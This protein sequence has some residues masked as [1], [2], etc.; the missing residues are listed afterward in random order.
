MRYRGKY[1]PPQYAHLRLFWVDMPAQNSRSTLSGMGFLPE[2]VKM[3]TF[4]PKM[5]YISDQLEPWFQSLVLLT[6][7]A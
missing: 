7:F 1:N 2:P 3:L 6:S 5:W 4:Y